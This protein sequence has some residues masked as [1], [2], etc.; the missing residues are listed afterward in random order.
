MTTIRLKCTTC[1]KTQDAT[2]KQIAEA[3]DNG[4]AFSA[5][6]HA[7]A[8]VDRVTENKEVKRGRI[9][10]ACYAV[11]VGDN[12]ARICPNCGAQITARAFRL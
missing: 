9:C 5:C 3:R 12:P 1:Q 7:V 2:E 8:T 6:C 11:S 4:C 10:Q